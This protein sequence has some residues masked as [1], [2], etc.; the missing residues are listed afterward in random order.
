MTS[1]SNCLRATHATILVVQ[2]RATCYLQGTTTQKQY[3]ISYRTSKHFRL[4]DFA[5][6]WMRFIMISHMQ[7]SDHHYCHRQVNGMVRTFLSLSHSLGIRLFCWFDPSCILLAH[8]LDLLCLVHPNLSHAHDYYQTC[9]HGPPYGQF[10]A[11]YKKLCSL[12]WCLSI[13]N[14][15]CFL[16]AQFLQK[17]TLF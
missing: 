12:I 8:I 13:N 2:A 1:T 3:S 9:M 6:Q 16:G 17:I 4:R 15:A 7:D 11:I 5:S 14:S 10:T